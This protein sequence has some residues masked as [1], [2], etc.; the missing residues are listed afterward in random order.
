M[1]TEI[2]AADVLSSYTSLMLTESNE[3]VRN[4]DELPYQKEL[5]KTVLR[6]CIKLAGAGKE[7]E[8]L[9][10]SYVR[11]ADFQPIS[12]D[13]RVSLDAWKSS[14]MGSSAEKMSDEHLLAVAKNLSSGGRAALEVKKRV[15]AE[16][17]VL[18]EEL[19]KAGF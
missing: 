16:A 11:L 18:L 13:E 1:A 8:F 12:E 17:E 10:S 7:R 9:R 5:I 4:I 6:H 15:A 19:K 2:D 14:L 3:V